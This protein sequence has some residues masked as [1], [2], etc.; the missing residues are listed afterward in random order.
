MTRGDL[1]K[2]E[3]RERKLGGEEIA[4]HIITPKEKE[5]HEINYNEVLLL[6]LDVYM[7]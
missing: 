6:S 2:T 1:S 3:K 7:L 4:N 5:S